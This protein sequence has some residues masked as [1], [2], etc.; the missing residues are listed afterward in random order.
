MTEYRL[1]TVWRIDAPL[2]DVYAAI[3]DSLDW[4]AWW[5]AVRQVE[6]IADGRP[7][8]IDSIRRY[9]WKGRLP[10][11]IRFEVRTTR[12]EEALAIEG[13]ASGDLDGCG[14]WRFA[15]EGGLSVVRYEWQVRC[16]RW[17]M[18][19]LSPLARPV[20]IANH[21]AVMRQ[22][23][24]ALARRLGARLVSAENVELTGAYDDS[25]VTGNRRR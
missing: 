7:D 18:R 16:T 6:T 15:S 19:L 22:G 12:I 10:Y 9:V 14:R 8:G 11:L 21:N 2:A 17:W 4:P 3:R 23:G 1:L 24:E 25:P 20:F 5:P 13:V